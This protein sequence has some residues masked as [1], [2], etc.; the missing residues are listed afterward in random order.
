MGQGADLLNLQRSK[1]SSVGLDLGHHK[2]KAVEMESTP[3]GWKVVRSASVPTPPDAIRDGVVVDTAG[4]TAA[5]KQLFKEARFNAPKVQIAAAGGA[6]FVRPVAFPKMNES[7]LRKTIRFE[8]S[9][10]V[11]GSIEDSF[12]DFSVVGPA[13]DDHMNVLVVAAP[14]EIVS[15]RVNVT[16][17]AGVEV[18]AVDVE[19]FAMF[20][21]ILETNQSEEGAL[22]TA[23]V[24]IGASSTSVSVVHQGQF[25]MNRSIPYGGTVLTEALK[26]YFKLSIEDAE[27]GKAQLN[28]EDLLGGDGPKENPPLRVVQPHVDDLVREVRRSLN[29]FQSQSGEGQGGRK[30][31]AIVLSGGG[32]KLAGIESYFSH[33]LGLP[34][35]L[36]GIYDNPRVLSSET[37]HDKGLD[38]AVAGGLAM[39]TNFKAA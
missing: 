24:D 39:R 12:V 7:T 31:E 35:T 15:T 37:E 3:S 10:Y 38:F 36:F 6:V 19:A 25:A 29:Y 21:A 23:I 27:E 22:T 11:P 20:R 16:E 32:A 8:A 4:V 33:K 26:A 34:V 1:K 17:A 28:L 14:K 30:V 9:R 18:E 13:E 2:L 5:L